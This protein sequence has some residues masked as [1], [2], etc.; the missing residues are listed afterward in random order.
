MI[1]V[2]A[3]VFYAALTAGFFYQLEYRRPELRDPDCE[4]KLVRLRQRLRAA[5]EQPLVLFV[6]SSRVLQGF[7]PDAARAECSPRYGEPLVYNFGI[8]GAYPFHNLFFMRRLLRSG[9][10]PSHVYVEILPALLLRPLPAGRLIAPERL[11]Y[12]DLTT[13]SSYS[14]TP[15]ETILNWAQKRALP[16]FTHRF[17]LVNQV[18]PELLPSAAWQNR[19]WE[20]LDADGWLQIPTFPWTRPDYDRSLQIAHSEYSAILQTATI[21]GA[22]E[23]A[24]R[25]L[26]SL[27]HDNDI[28]LTFV[29]MPEGS[30]YRSWYSPAAREAIDAFLSRLQHDFGADIVDAR[31]WIA[32]DDFLDSHHLLPRG[33]AAFASRLG[34]E[35]LRFL[36]SPE[37]R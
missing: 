23:R 31:T 6:G 15:I 10:R 5:P 37:T 27:C 25:E 4:H 8:P 7:R 35:H 34:R 30:T 18:A 36:F 13:Y 26:V 20:H 2:Y 14:A 33:A 28:A 21:S 16:W 9:I 22:Q 12:R 32:D 11:S 3:L 17:I 19:Y 1:L 29:V 24:T